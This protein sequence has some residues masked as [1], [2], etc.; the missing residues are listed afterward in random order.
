MRRHAFFL[1]AVLALAGCADNGPPADRS[2]AESQLR[3]ANAAY[4]RAIVTADAAALDALLADDYSY[5][6][7]EG[8][9]RDKATQI[10][11]LTSNRMQVMSAGSEDVTIR[12]IGDHALVIGRFPARIH[13]GSATVP[14]NERYSSLWSRQDG[15]WRLRHEHASLI[16]ERRR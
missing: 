1:A 7:A 8:E 10:A 9:V 13:V 3:Q 11:N 4:D 16:P 5:V 6:T 2:E 15:R 12:W 14:M